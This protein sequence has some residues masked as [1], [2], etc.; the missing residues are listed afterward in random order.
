M[1]HLATLQRAAGLTGSIVLDPLPSAVMEPRGRAGRD[2]KVAR[3]LGAERLGSVP[4]WQQ[5]VGFHRPRPSV[6]L[7]PAWPVDLGSKEA[8]SAVDRV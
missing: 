4:G 6:C 1:P 2:V 5:P 3:E 8:E 7:V